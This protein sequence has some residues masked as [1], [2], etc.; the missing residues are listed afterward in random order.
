[1]LAWTLWTDINLLGVDVALGLRDLALTD[2]ERGDL[3]AK[4]RELAAEAA[5]IQGEKL[6][7]KKGGP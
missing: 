1:M 4:L 3:L 7:E 6:Q 2:F 5:K